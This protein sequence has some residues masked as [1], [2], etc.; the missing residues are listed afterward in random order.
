M[1]AI[2]PTASFWVGLVVILGVQN[3]LSTDW[4]KRCSGCAQRYWICSS[5]P[6]LLFRCQDVR[7]TWRTN[8]LC[9]TRHS[10]MTIPSESTK[11]HFLFISFF[12]KINSSFVALKLWLGV[13]KFPREGAGQATKINVK[14]RKNVTLSP[15]KS[16]RRFQRNSVKML[17]IVKPNIERNAKNQLTVT[18]KRAKKSRMR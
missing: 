16:V 10:V 13:K 2:C 17:R 15:R 7:T 6:L 1:L 3:K 11:N 8:A 14:L 9:A 5:W 4:P 12:M 18:V